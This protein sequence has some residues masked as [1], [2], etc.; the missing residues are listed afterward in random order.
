[1]ETADLRFGTM[2]NSFRNTVEIEHKTGVCEL[3][4]DDQSC[5]DPRLRMNVIELIV[6][7]IN[8][9]ARMN[10]I[11]LVVFIADLCGWTEVIFLT[12]SIESINWNKKFDWFCVS[13]QLLSL[14]SGYIYFTFTL[15]DGQEKI[16]KL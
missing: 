9:H 5:D 7:P 8:I 3:F 2:D 15:I 10:V 14:I 1:M 6:V 4:L 12:H 13:T 11:K 16:W